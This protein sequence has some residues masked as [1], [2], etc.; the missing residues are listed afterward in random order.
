MTQSDHNYS[1]QGS[2][3][4]PKGKNTQNMSSPTNVN[5][6]LKCKKTEFYT[7][8]FKKENELQRST[9]MSSNNIMNPKGMY[10]WLYVYLDRLVSS[11]YLVLVSI[12][13][14]EIGANTREAS[15][16]KIVPR[17][18]IWPMVNSATTNWNCSLQCTQKYLQTL[19]LKSMSL[20]WWHKSS[21]LYF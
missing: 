8:Q 9:L 3:G 15:I 18:T 20:Q 16:T 19:Y 6:T 21:I 7:C 2:V 14:C 11:R 1:R 10:V 4:F 5:I 17:S 13:L 12:Y